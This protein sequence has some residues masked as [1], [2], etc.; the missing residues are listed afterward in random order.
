MCG[1]KEM[2]GLVSET[3]Y[4]WFCLDVMLDIETVWGCL[5]FLSCLTAE[6]Y[7]T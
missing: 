5:L 6:I 2:Q 1:S 7:I 4:Y 3:V